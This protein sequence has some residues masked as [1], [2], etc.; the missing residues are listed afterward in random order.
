MSSKL[1]CFIG[2]VPVI[3]KID[4]QSSPYIVDRMYV[5]MYACCLSWLV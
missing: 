3:D 4:E 2:L 5:C 1:K